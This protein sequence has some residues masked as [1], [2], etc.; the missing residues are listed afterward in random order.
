MHRGGTLCL[1]VALLGSATSARA[2]EYQF[3]TI[4]PPEAQ[5]TLANGINNEGQIVGYYFT[6]SGDPR[7][8]VHAFLLSG[9]VLTPLADPQGD[10]TTPASIN[11]TGQI[12]GS[13]NVGLDQHAFVLNGGVY[14]T[15]D[16][17]GRGP[18]ASAN[19]INNSGRVIGYFTDPQQRQHGFQYANGQFVTRDAPNSSNTVGFGINDAGQ[20]VGEVDT[21]SGDTYGFLM[22]NGGFAPIRF[23]GAI[24]TVARAINNQGDIVGTYVDT[25]SATHGFLVHDGVFTTLDVPGAR[26]TNPTGINDAGQIVGWSET[27]NFPTGFLATP[28]PEPA[29]LVPVFVA[30]AWLVT[31]NRTRLPL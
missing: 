31:R 12:A 16:P 29:M 25:A 18:F 6:G 26:L 3:T 14:S 13:Y 2:A 30:A 19:G 23:P 4:S 11:D 17:P 27:S 22:V 15:I 7:V 28:V 5:E 9:G 1:L 20:G 24:L 10:S 8:V 21:E